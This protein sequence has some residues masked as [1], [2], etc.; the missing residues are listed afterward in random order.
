VIGFVRL[1]HAVTGDQ[2]V[3]EYFC[4]RCEHAWT[5]AEP[6]RRSVP[7][8]VKRVRETSKPSAP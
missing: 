3:I 8:P 4:D 2:S 1:E 7:R 6:E 5:V